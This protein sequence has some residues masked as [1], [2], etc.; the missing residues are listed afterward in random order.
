MDEPSMAFERDAPKA[1]RHSTLR[2]G[3]WKTPRT[4]RF[5][6]SEPIFTPQSISI[7]GE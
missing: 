6:K 4:Q 1:A 5:G 3:C 7:T 2:C